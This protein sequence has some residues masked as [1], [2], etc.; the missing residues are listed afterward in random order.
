MLGKVP[1][2]EDTWLRRCWSRG[3]NRDLKFADLPAEALACHGVQVCT[4]DSY[5][6]DLLGFWPDE[7][8]GTVVRLADEKR[9]TPM[10]SID[11]D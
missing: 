9:R 11:P 3:R 7:V 8:L 5:L 6:C 2:I 4:P 1:T 10:T